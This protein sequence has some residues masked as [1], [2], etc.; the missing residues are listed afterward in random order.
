MTDAFLIA[1]NM[2]LTAS[3]IILVVVLARLAL[4]RAPRWCS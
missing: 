4:K 1:V 2:S 3:A